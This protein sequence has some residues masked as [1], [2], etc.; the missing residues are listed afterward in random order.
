MQA[1]SALCNKC[2]GARGSRVNRNRQGNQLYPCSQCE[3][4]KVKKLFSVDGFKRDPKIC[5]IC[6]KKEKG[7]LSKRIAPKTAPETVEVLVGESNTQ[8]Y[9]LTSG[10]ISS[11]K[12]RKT[13][14]N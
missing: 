8:N 13:K 7:L 1:A 5:N 2:L 14:L 10:N 3:T 11:Y 6:E 12:K 4:D 9:H